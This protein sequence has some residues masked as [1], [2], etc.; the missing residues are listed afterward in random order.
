MASPVMGGNGGWL[1]LR[2]RRLVGPAFDDTVTYGITAPGY[3]LLLG[4]LARL[5]GGAAVE[6]PGWGSL[7]S[8]ASLR[9]GPPARIRFSRR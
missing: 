6:I 9:N 3:A 8:L 2:I 5:T 4:L 1:T 7:I